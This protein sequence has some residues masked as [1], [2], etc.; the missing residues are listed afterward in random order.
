MNVNTSVTNCGGCGR[1]CATPANATTNCAA[2][3]CGFTCNAGFANCDASASNGCEVNLNTS[4]PHCG[5]CGRACVLPNA[6]AG[7][8]AGF[9]A[10]SACNAGFDDC[11][12]SAS[13][14]CEVNVNTS[15][16]NCGACG[17]RCPARANA[18]TGC[19]AGFC[20]V[21][22][23][24]AG[25]ANCD[26][27]ASNGCEVNLRTSVA[28][29]GACGNVCPSGLSCASGVCVCPAGQSYCGGTCV[30]VATDPTN[31]GACGVACASGQNCVAGTCTT[32]SSANDTPTGAVVLSMVAPTQTITASTFGATNQSACGSG[33]DVYYRFTLTARELVY[34]DTFGTAYNTLLAFAPSTGAGTVAGTC[35]DDV[36]GVLQTQLT[37]VLEPGTYFVV[38]SGFGTSSGLFTL[39]FQHLP[40][41]NGT[42]TQLTTL[43]GSQTVTGTTSG[44]SAIT[45]SCGSGLGPENTY[46]FVTCPSFTATI[47]SATTC[48]ATDTWDT[49]LEQR[50]ATRVV[51]ACND[52]TCGLRSSVGSTI[53]AGAGLHSLYVD[54]N[55]S[56]S[57]GAYT[58]TLAFGSCVSSLTLCSATCVD[59][60]SS[61][62]HCG[63]CG[64]ACASGTTCIAGA[65]R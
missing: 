14:G 2:G 32:S 44:T 43:S 38:V 23:C 60:G 47:F 54:G 36:C 26:G 59:L 1:V 16:T 41:G 61:A 53:P 3:A 28:N 35:T 52:N 58:A 13:D 22:A 46:W 8:A 34:A 18:T 42:V 31:C 40:V 29:C 17:N 21:S 56:S 4:A 33:G 12:A 62:T 9:C 39:H 45:T 51:T 48:S 64:R 57:L 30:S 20:A 15:V 6:T 5:A 27:D 50:S 49:V 24:N 19:A 11:D 25:F 7:C 10:V 65:C 37:R 55:S 63:A